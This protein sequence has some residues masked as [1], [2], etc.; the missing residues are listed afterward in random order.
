MIMICVIPALMK[1]G[2]VQFLCENEVSQRI[3]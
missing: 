2:L 3:R 1:K